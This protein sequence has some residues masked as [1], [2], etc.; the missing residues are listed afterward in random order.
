MV[1]DI[2]VPANTRGAMQAGIPHRSMPA[3]GAGLLRLDT[4][5]AAADGGAFEV[6]ADDTAV[7]LVIVVDHIDIRGIVV[8]P[9]A[10]AEAVRRALADQVAIHDGQHEPVA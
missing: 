4:D 6:A 3:P 10:D 2:D 8:M 1:R 5:A 9:D 7:E